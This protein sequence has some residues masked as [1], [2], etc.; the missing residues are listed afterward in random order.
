MFPLISTLNELRR[1]KSELTDIMNDLETHGIPFNRDIP[2]GIM[3]EVPATVITL[4]RYIDE[5]DFIS[6]GTNDLIQYA[7]AVDRSNTEVASLYRASDP[8]VL[9]LIEMSVQAAKQGSVSA[10]LCGQMSGNPKYTMLLLGLGL[11][12]FS[13]PPVAVPEIKRVCR[14]VTIAQCEQL[15]QRAMAMDDAEEISTLLHEELG[16]IAPELMGY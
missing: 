7:L 11:R 3:V 1:A 10:S 13:V 8:S 6:I 15:A 14:S 16:K 12:T 9:R 4:E 5:I 2:I